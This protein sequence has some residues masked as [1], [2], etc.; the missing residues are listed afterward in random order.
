MF[1]DAQL[2]GEIKFVGTSGRVVE[3][4]SIACNLLS[5]ALICCSKLKMKC[6]NNIYG[7]RDC[8]LKKTYLTFCFVS[9]APVNAGILSWF[10][11][12]PLSSLY[13]MFD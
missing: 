1:L 2:K 6:N 9:L 10:V 7:I 4:L 3:E 12:F 11:L 13:V 5:I 8:K